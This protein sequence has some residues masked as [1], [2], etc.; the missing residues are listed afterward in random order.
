MAR[1]IASP[2][3]GFMMKQRGLPEPDVRKRILDVDM[4]QDGHVV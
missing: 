1:Y 4:K 2:R 3:E